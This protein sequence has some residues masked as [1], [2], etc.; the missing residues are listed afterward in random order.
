MEIFPL[1]HI[2]ACRRRTLT[3]L[4]APNDASH[5]KL[6]DAAL[7]SAVVFGVRL[8]IFIFIYK[9]TALGRF[10]IRLGIGIGTAAAAIPTSARSSS[11]LWPLRRPKWM[12]ET[13]LHA[14]PARMFIS[15]HYFGKSILGRHRLNG[16]V[17]VGEADSFCRVCNANISA[18]SGSGSGRCP[19]ILVTV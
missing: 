18:G 6:S 13:C 8:E 15:G 4:N 5:H 2:G 14:C 16:W 9:N 19:H 1:K 3:N 7:G 17:G 12:V 10:R 11:L